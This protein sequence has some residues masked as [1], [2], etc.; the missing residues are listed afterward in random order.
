MAQA[1]RLYRVYSAAINK[2]LKRT[3]HCPD[4]AGA[5]G[6]GGWALTQRAVL[7][8]ENLLTRL[9]TAQ[10]FLGRLASAAAAKMLALLSAGRLG[11]PLDPL[12]APLSPLPPPL[13]LDQARTSSLSNPSSSSAART[14]PRLSAALLGGPLVPVAPPLAP[15]SSTKTVAGPGVEHIVQGARHNG[16]TL[17]PAF[18][19]ARGCS[20]PA[21][22]ENEKLNSDVASPLGLLPW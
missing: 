11:G 4:G 3:S 17:R 8:T 20:T 13:P 7:D 22:G 16:G 21:A 19:K 1:L 2:N 5:G 15:S 10:R 9:N 18:G 6:T 12:P 14:L